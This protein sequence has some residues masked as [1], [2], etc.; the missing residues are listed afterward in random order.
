MENKIGIIGFGSLGASYG[1]MALD[2]GHHVTYICDDA[3]KEKYSK[4]TFSVNATPYNFEFNTDS[5]EKYDLILIT[6]KIQHLASAL[7][8]LS[9]YD[10]SDTIVISVINGIRSEEIIAAALPD[11]KVL[12]A[13]T[14]KTDGQRQKN[15]FSY[16][17]RG[18]IVFGALQ[19]S[20][21]VWAD[22]AEEI[23]KAANIPHQKVDNIEYKLWWKLMLNV[24]INQSSAILGSPYGKYQNTHVQ[25]V[26]SA[27][28]LEVVSVSKAA[29]VNLAEEDIQNCFSIFKSLNPENKTS[30]LQDLEH[31]RQTEVDIFAGEVIALGKKYGIDTPI[32]KLLYHAIHYLQTN[33]IESSTT[34]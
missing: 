34:Q 30:M 26:A 20:N 29:G 7:E 1:S 32:N 6:V 18:R 22:K 12:H 9:K 15:N 13:Y 23:F 19:D 10:T 4:S 5:A 25:Q 27:A 21:Q 28:M 3:R 31:G 33:P 2:G 16:S 11:A 17:N 24:G 14:V 8:L